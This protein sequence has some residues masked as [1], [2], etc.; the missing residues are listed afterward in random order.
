VVP[1]V[2][3]VK[4]VKID[5]EGGLGNQLFQYAAARAL[6]GKHDL[7]IFDTGSYS[8]DY[9]NRR[10]RL[11]NFHVKGRV[12]SSRV[13]KKLFTPRTRL[14]RLAS[15]LGL[16]GFVREEGFRFHADRHG[17][18]RVF[19]ATRGFWQTEKY[20]RHIRFELIQEI[21]PKRLPALPPLLMRRNS[22]AVHVRRGDYLN[23]DR[24][25]FV[26]E[27]YYR[28]AMDRMRHDLKNPVFIFFS[29]DL[30]WC[31]RYFD[32]L[33]CS[34]ADEQE[35][36]D[37]FLQLY[38]M[39]RCNHQIIANSSFSWWGAWLNQNDR[40]IVI[41]PAKPFRDQSLV[42]ESHYPADWIAV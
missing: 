30:G 6:K 2:A 35:W 41:R 14:N 4:V 38:L 1:I 31:K 7:L 12:V 27:K 9:L 25:G 20:F 21:V 37:D 16:F 3:K 40:K 19:T 28:D 13:V 22:V 5:F 24:Y 11:N 17:Q 39:S 33:D 10:F 36:K 26:G 42:Y 23:D 18:A 29:D 32:K 34:F 15:S 8:K